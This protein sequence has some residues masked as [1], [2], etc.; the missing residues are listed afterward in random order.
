[1]YTV[2]GSEDERGK[3]TDNI[4]PY[5]G[6]YGPTKQRCPT[7]D[8]YIFHGKNIEKHLNEVIDH[9]FLSQQQELQ[10]TTDIRRVYFYSII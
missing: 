10:S 9:S 2:A 3:L 6:T 1:M 7:A 5:D 4:R 8:F